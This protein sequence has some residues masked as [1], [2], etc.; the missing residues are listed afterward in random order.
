MRRISL[1]KKLRVGAVVTVIAAAGA[2]GTVIATGQ[3]NSTARLT[4]VRGD[5]SSHATGGRGDI[6]VAA[7]YLGLERAQLRDELRSGRTLAE[8]AGGTAGRSASGLIDAL[9]SARAARLQAAVADKKLPAAKAGK[10]LAGLRKRVTLEVNRIHRDRLGGP[11]ALKVAASYLG[12]GRAQLRSD[13][14]SGRTLAAIADAT[15]GRS[16]AGLIEALVAAAKARLAADLAAGAL[17]ATDE[18]ARLATLERRVRSLVN[19]VLQA[20]A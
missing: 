7:A 2:A 9:V 13:L 16:A 10:R 5:R 4:A 20:H 12:L 3:G 19:R 6:A 15:Q 17:T 1:S 11:R 14:R 18:K 8:I